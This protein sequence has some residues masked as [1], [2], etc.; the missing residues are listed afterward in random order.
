VFEYTVSD[1][2]RCNSTAGVDC[3]V[4]CVCLCVSYAQ[5]TDNT[6][7]ATA[8]AVQRF[9]ASCRFAIL[10]ANHRS[11]IEAYESITMRNESVAGDVYYTPE[12]ETLN[13]IS[14]PLCLPGRPVAECCGNGRCANGTCQCNTGWFNNMIIDYHYSL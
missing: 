6:T 1:S 4:L 5:L 8:G 11:Y 2:D 9:L 13:R 3:V 12:I 14:C 7:L 10:Q